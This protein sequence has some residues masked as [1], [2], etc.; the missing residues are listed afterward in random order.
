MEKFNTGNKDLDTWLSFYHNE[1]RST[2]KFLYLLGKL[3]K[4]FLISAPPVD[5]EDN[6]S[7]FLPEFGLLDFDFK[8][9]AFESQAEDTLEEYTRVVASILYNVNLEKMKTRYKEDFNEVLERSLIEGQ[10]E[11]HGIEFE[12][13]ITV[14]L[15]K[16]LIGR[17]EFMALSL[18]RG[19]K[20]GK[21]YPDKK[22]LKLLNK[23]VFQ[24]KI[25][26]L[27]HI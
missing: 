24:N 26:K 23:E 17:S 7:D 5:I 6:M 25:K 8:K 12:K 27:V 11:K 22:S 9:I 20:I 10:Y 15:Q 2:T 3:D 13:V 14:A 4:S 18:L 19:L 21:R 1:K 16:N